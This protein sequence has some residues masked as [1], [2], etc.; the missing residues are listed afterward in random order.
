RNRK[1]ILSNWD[2]ADGEVIAGMLASSLHELGL[3]TLGFQTNP[4]A[5]GEPGNQDA[6]QFTELAGQVLWGHA[7]KDH[8]ASSNGQA[9]TLIVQPNFELLLL[10][11]DYQTLYK[12]LPFS[13]VN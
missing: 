1:T 2:G 12:L 9:R 7:T 13:K 4:A 8:E 11:P 3:V 10:Q 5:S 6:F